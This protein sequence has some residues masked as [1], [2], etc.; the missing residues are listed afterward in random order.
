MQTKGLTKG[1]K[2]VNEVGG[3]ISI[4]FFAI[5]LKYLIET[6]Y[7]LLLKYSH[8]ILIPIKLPVKYI[9]N[10]LVLKINLEE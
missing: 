7:I 10:N 6:I 5:Q 4:Y 3:A 1:Y 9:G 2:K 8:N